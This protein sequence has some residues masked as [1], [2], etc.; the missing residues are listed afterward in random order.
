MTDPVET[1]LVSTTSGPVLTVETL[2]AT[3]KR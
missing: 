2:I 1:C 3:S